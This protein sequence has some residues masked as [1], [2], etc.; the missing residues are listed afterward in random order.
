MKPLFLHTIYETKSINLQEKMSNKLIAARNSITSFLIELMKIDSTTGK[1]G[2][3]ANAIKGY[4]EAEDWHVL[5]QPLSND[6]Q[7]FNLL[8]TKT[9]DSTPK[10]IFNTH[11]DTV[12]P[13]LPPK[14]DGDTIISGRGS[15]DAKGQIASMSFA[16]KRIAQ[17]HPDLAN[18]IGLLLVVGEETDH[19]G[20]LEAN[21]L[22]LSPDYL[23]VGE[24]TELR[25]GHAQKGALKVSICE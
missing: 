24:P 14:Q 4:F 12:P 23:V 21:N 19:V 6:S 3:L 1:E 20:M 18:Q 2:Q 11:L 5:T 16:L 22:G 10:L 25:F 9:S 8:I 15:N 13:Y 7:R 17:E